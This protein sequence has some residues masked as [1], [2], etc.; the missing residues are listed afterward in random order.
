MRSSEGSLRLTVDE[1]QRYEQL[2]QAARR[3]IPPHEDLSVA[4]IDTALKDAIFA[5]ADIRA[6]RS[7]DVEVRIREAI[8]EFRTFVEGPEY[9]YECWL[10]VEG[11]ELASLPAQFANTRFALVGDAEIESLSNLVKQKQSVA[12][13]EKL[14]YIDRVAKEIRERPVAIQ[15]VK[16][17]DERAAL[18]LAT[19]EVQVTLECLNFFADA[20]PYNRARLWISRGGSRRGSSLQ[21]ALA[22]E[23]SLLY[24]P[25][26]D[27]PWEF[28]LGRLRELDGPVG[29]ALARVE[30]LRAK[31]ERSEVEELLL[32]AVRLVGRAATAYRPEDKFLFSVIALDC[33]VRPAGG[34]GAGPT[35]ASRVARVLPGSRSDR[36]RLE[37][38]LRELYNVRSALVHDGSLEVTEDDRAVVHTI[39]LRTV[40]WALTS[41][42]VEGHVSLH[43]LEGYFD[44]ITSVSHG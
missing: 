36:E 42:D 19:R 43:D 12:S 16:A 13:A 9:G 40:V 37:S 44:Q 20:V 23:G 39:A 34:H 5:V 1:S 6:T 11:L 10:E 25:K 26:A 35:V 30:T 28:S 21:M 27:V 2:L 7:S 18:S 22:D 3:E 38:Q 24:S 8:A 29:D 4:A 33:I 17:R 15:Q 32:R 14:E 31:D 41:P